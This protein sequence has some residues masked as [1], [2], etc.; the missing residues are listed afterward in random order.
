MRL[1]SS[2]VFRCHKTLE[3]LT[4]MDMLGNGAKEID[5]NAPSLFFLLVFR[6]QH[7]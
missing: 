5:V 6:I 3:A 7:D 4:E 2:R 1:V